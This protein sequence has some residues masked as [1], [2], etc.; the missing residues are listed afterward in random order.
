MVEAPET[1]TGVRNWIG[2]LAA[3]RSTPTFVTPPGASAVIAWNVDGDE[4]KL[5]LPEP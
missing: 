1:D 2:A 5:T 4:M 3:V